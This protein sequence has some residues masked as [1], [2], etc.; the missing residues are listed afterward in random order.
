VKDNGHGVTREIQNKVF[1]PFFSTKPSGIGLGLP[2]V[3]RIVNDH[4]GTTT[5]DSQFK[6]GTTVRLAFYK[7]QSETI[8]GRS[9]QRDSL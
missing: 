8:N 1:E 9:T 3:A 2:T 6:K 5:F 7:E 4:G